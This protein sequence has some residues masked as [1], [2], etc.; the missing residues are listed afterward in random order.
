MTGGGAS[1][2]MRVA[3]STLSYGFA[4][5]AGMSGAVRALR[6]ASC[7]W[8]G[9]RVALI[10][11]RTL[12][13]V[14]VRGAGVDR[15]RSAGGHIALRGLPDHLP[16]GRGGGDRDGVRWVA[17]L[18]QGLDRDGLGLPDGERHHRAVLASFQ[19]VLV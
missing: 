8:T 3:L 16:T 2:R 5:D 6:C 4:S 1:P 19:V 7:E 12:G 11:F 18:G 15:H 10:V 13:S 9:Y 14:C 17:G